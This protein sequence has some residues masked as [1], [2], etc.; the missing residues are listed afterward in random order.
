ME[1][2][3]NIT[4]YPNYQISNH[5]NVK[6]IK[7]QKVLKPSLQH[8]YCY[9]KLSSN[10]GNLATTIHVLVATAFIPKIDG[11]EFVDHIDHDRTN[12]HTNNLRWVTRQE[13]CCN[14]TK[15]SS[16]TSSQY[17]GVCFRSD[18]NRWVA[19]ITANGKKKH[20]GYFANEIDAGKAYN[21][22]AIEL[23]GEY[24]SLNVFD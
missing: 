14:R 17:K 1:I 9:V 11:S 8:G 3:A 6:V 18:R 13:N 12:N 2:F 19:E 5:G 15:Q 20:I 24:A 10:V 21:E 16:R 7:T 22:K 4:G 23:H